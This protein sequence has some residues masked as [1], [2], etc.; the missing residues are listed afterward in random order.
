MSRLYVA[1]TSGIFEMISRTTT[2]TACGTPSPPVALIG[3]ALFGASAGNLAFALPSN[4]IGGLG[5]SQAAWLAAVTRAGVSWNEAVVG[6]LA[7]YVVTL[8]SALLFGG[9]AVAAGRLGGAAEGERRAE[10]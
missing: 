2:S 9:I 1:A 7:L 3:V 5:A 10:P 8:A 4:G 6:A